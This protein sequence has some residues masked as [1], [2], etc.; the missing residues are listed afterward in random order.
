MKNLKFVVGFVGFVMTSLLTIQPS[1]VWAMGSGS[2]LP[3]LE[4]VKSVDLNRYMGK[5]YEILRLPQTFEKGCAGVS[6][7][8]ALRPD[9]KV[10]VKNSCRK[11]SCEGKLST[12]NG[13]AHV[14]DADKPAQLKVSFFW[15][16]E[17]DYWILDLASDYSYV[18]VGAPDRKSFWILSRK[19]TLDESITEGL[20]AKFQKQGFD[21]QN[22]I[23]TPTCGEN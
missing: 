11:D 1:T 9:G 4:T 13:V 6:A 21:F 10:D 7:E 5:W 16:F 18:A 3:R 2:S 8:Y 15:P 19:P 17:G 20:L 23:R 22:I 12:A 14:V